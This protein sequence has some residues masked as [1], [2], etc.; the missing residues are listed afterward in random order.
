MAF[1]NSASRYRRRREGW[2]IRRNLW[3]LSALFG[4]FAIGAATLP[5]P[6]WTCA[7]GAV[8][9]L[10][11]V[12][13][14][15]GDRWRSGALL[16]A[17]IAVVIGLLD[18]LAGWLTPAAHGAGLSTT[19]DPQEWTVADT[20]LGYRPRPNTRILSTSRFGSE[21][22]FRVAYT[23][24]GDS[25]RVTPAAPAGADTYL[26]MGDS[27]VFGQG[28]AD[29]ETL[30]AQFA[31]AKDFK[32]GTVNFSA[33]GYAPNQLVRALETGRLDRLANT[34][35][36]AVVTWIIPAHL[37]RVAGDGPWFGSSPSYRLQD[38]GL[39]YVGSFGA[40]R[41]LHPFSGLRHLADQQFAF[42]HAFGTEERQQ[43][44]AEIFVALMLRL[45]ALVHKKF[46]A[47]LVVVY[48]WPDEGSGGGD[49]L[50][51]ATRQVLVSTLARLRRH[52]MQMVSVD[53]AES[54]YD[55]SRLLIPHDGHPTALANRL[56]AA[57][58]DRRLPGR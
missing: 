31:Q 39:R 40:Y 58:L 20:E 45:Q 29:D 28:L 24:D 5:S 25:A 37:G 57:E 7:L 13:V 48:S 52:G 42:V 44:Q 53:K 14:L 46:G 19:M 56:I 1:T 27:F 34:P 11:G 43:S 18:I 38:G 16:L 54:G 3:S 8:L 30:A 49:G 55:V 4:L 47:P 32:V 23:I 15:R 26:F 51:G 35:V 2:A 33:P 21:T 10:T 17:A 50:S 9:G 41:W 22:I 12:I 36:K 6:V